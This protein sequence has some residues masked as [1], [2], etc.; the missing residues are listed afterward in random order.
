MHW[1]FMTAKRLDGWAFFLTAGLWLGLPA[2]AWAQ[3]SGG[4]WRLPEAGSTRAATGVQPS[5]GPQVVIVQPQPNA[6]RSTVFRRR[7]PYG[8]SPYGQLPYGAT[9]I[10]AVLLQNGQ[11]YAD[12]G[13]GFEPVYRSCYAGSVVVSGQPTVIGSNGVVLSPAPPPTYTQPVPNQQ[14][15]SQQMAARTTGTQRVVV[16][17]AAQSACYNRDG[18]G[19]LF[20]VRF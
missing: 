1:S 14:T 4:V 2:V 19:R 17:G 3:Q 18:A 15:A 6:Q 8:H 16:S 12:F 11:V 7:A 5:P 9:V 20:V 10:P 13:Y